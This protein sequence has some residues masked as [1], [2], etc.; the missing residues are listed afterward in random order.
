M[1]DSKIDNNLSFGER[2][3]HLRM[4]K[5]MSQKDFAQSVDI[6]PVH[7]NRYEKGATT[8]AAETLS[9]LADGLGVSVDYLLEGEEQDAA[10]A[11]LKDREL[12][13]LFKEIEKCSPE[14]KDHAKYTLKAYIKAEKIQTLAS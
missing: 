2:L 5:G 11:D 7:Y 4:Q 10:V 9:K 12:L 3:K 1:A 8:P 13:E 14:V 6:H